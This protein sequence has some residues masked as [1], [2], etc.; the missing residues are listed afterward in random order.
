MFLRTYISGINNS[1]LIETVQ[2]TSND[3]LQ[4]INEHFDVKKQLNALLLGNVQSGKTAQM[5][6]IMSAMADNGYKIFI[7]LTTDNVDL[8]RQTYK[9]VKESLTNFTVLNEKEDSLFTIATLSKP[10]VLV[11]KKNSRVLSRWK[12]HLFNTN[13]CKGLFLAIFDD[14]ADSSSLN[15]LINKDRISIIN[16]RLTEIKE[17]AASTI[18]IEVTATPQAV[19]LQTQLS[20]WKPQFIYYFKPGSKYLGGNYFYPKTK[21][22]NTVFT[23]NFELDEIKNGGD[24]ICP[25]G[26]SRSVLSFLVNCAHRKIN[27]ITN[28]NFMIH[29]SIKIAIHNQFIETVQDH[30]TLLQKST[31]D[32]A[33]ISNLQD[34]W[35]D[36]QQTK[37]DLENFEDIKNTVIDILDNT[38][39]ALIPLNSKSYVC[40]DSNNPDALDLSKGFNIIVGGNTL[41]RGITFPNLQTVYY[42]RSSKMP[43]ADT[44]WQHSRIFG[45]DREKQMV[46]IFIPQPLYTLFA[47]LNASNEILIKQVEDNI[48][49][50]QLI[51]PVGIKPTRKN[52]INNKYLNL[53]QGGVNMFASAPIA[54]NVDTIN[55]LIEKYTSL[56]YIDIDIELLIKLL[57]LVK[58]ESIKDFDK[59]K[60]I[61]CIK[62]LKNQKPQIRCKLI[63]RVNREIAKNSGTLLSPNDRTLGDRFKNEVVLTMYRI[64]GSIEKGWEGK[65]LWIPNIKFPEDCCFYDME[66]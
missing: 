2:E 44:F 24:V 31:D 8:H 23:K 46:R 30:L 9:R 19:I 58:S 12:N 49:K 48:E 50:V 25:I 1:E 40:R 61:A 29:P 16:K 34:E 21:S 26:L 47:E 51:Y 55:K 56:Q 38:E 57:N 15:T 10:T 11:L 17:T 62:G 52:V 4:K 45:Y 35:K 3:F 59:N 43:Q 60:F 66:L 22:L 5:L 20:G 6:G 18:Y 63:V 32:K 37:P 36:L 13:I 14:E 33:F 65:P 42:C 28:C 54:A 39:I 64:N 27:G 53:L 7:L 41:G